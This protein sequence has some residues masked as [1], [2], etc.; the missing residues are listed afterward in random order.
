MRHGHSDITI[1][2][3]VTESD[4]QV[5]A[6]IMVAS[7]PWTTLGYTHA[8]CLQALTHPVCV[9]HVAYRQLEVC[10]FFVLSLSG[11][12]SGYLQLLG[13]AQHYRGQGL[14]SWLL[15]RAEEDIFARHANAFLCVS[16][17]NQGARRFY[18]HHGYREI[19]ELTDYVVAGC[20]EILM[21][22]S[23]GPINGYVGTAASS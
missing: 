19:G 4:A 14:G 22:K 7:E 11:P 12:F 23:R 5:C 16:S 8:K 20:S 1:T 18:Q 3:L 17:F 9:C 13:V 2:P 21:R 15:Q 6:D 10:G